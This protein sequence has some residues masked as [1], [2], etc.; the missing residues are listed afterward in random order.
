MTPGRKAA[1]PIG[2]PNLMIYFKEAPYRLDTSERKLSNCAQYSNLRRACLL[3]GLYWV[4]KT[5]R[6]FERLVRRHLQRALFEER[7]PAVSG[8]RADLT[9]QDEQPGGSSTDMANAAKDLLGRANS[10][11]LSELAASALQL[12]AAVDY[13]DRLWL[14]EEL[15]DDPYSF[16]REFEGRSTYRT[17]SAYVSRVRTDVMRAQWGTLDVALSRVPGLFIE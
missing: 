4:F 1:D 15:R 7:F 2:R 12:A 6:E 13:P 8:V 9:A 11:S 14:E 3:E 17:L 16:R 5:P 10:I